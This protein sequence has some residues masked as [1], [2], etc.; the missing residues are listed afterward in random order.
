MG[1]GESDAAR[2]LLLPESASARLMERKGVKPE[3]LPV[4]FKSFKGSQ[5]LKVTQ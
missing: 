3:R 5:Q 1:G 2:D 4:E